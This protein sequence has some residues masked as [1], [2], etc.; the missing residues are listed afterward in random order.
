MSLCI[1]HV[2]KPTLIISTSDNTV[3]TDFASPMKFV[4]TYVLSKSPCMYIHERV[5]QLPHC[6][7]LWYN[8]NVL[9][10]PRYLMYG[11]YSSLYPYL[12]CS[13]QTSTYSSLHSYLM[14]STQ[15][16]TYSSLRSY[17]MYSTQTSTCSSLCP[18]L[19]YCNTLTCVDCQDAGTPGSRVVDARHSSA[20]GT[21]PDSKLQSPLIS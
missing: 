4:H 7:P 2:H 5:I 3:S 8:V 13:T 18:Y 14:C 21:V 20:A 1:P 17:L 16:S 11:T 6:V 15:T 12:M 19:I 10:V 9:F